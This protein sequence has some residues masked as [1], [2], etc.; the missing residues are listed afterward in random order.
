MTTGGGTTYASVLTIETSG[1]SSA[2]IRTDRGGG[3]VVVDGG[4]YTTNGLGSPAIYSTADIT[5]SNATLVS[6]LSEGVCIEGKN[7]IT[8]T[9]CDLTADNTQCNG[10]ATF[11]DTIMIY[12]SMS[13]DADTGTS[14]FTMTGGSLT[15]KSGH[16]FHVTNTHA[17]I[18][19]S[20]VDIANEDADNVLLSVCDDGWNGGNHH[21]EL[22][23]S[24]QT[25]S[26]AILVGSSAT[27][28]LSLTDG[29]TFT[30]SITGEITNSRGDDI[31][32]E[33]GEASVMLDEG[34]TWT[35]TA[36]SY[37]TRFTGNAEQIV[38]NGY[39]LYVN[40]VALEGTKA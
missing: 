37:V 3:T 33:A 20:G 26:G 8:L 14:A 5:V 25:L 17:I 34:S 12:Q 21:A 19:L 36:D 24:A 22:N 15:S 4:S 38:S 1:R 11:L 10:N 40:G 18:T 29:S 31:S 9:D 35:L 28:S 2:A 39:T 30:G 32:T 16:V 13:G 7:S 27:L 6:N 23:A